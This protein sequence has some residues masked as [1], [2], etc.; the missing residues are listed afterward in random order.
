MFMMERKALYIKIVPKKS[1]NFPEKIFQ[2]IIENR[3]KKN[4][5]WL[6]T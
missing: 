2:K 6:Q 1:K 5:K 3:P 4:L